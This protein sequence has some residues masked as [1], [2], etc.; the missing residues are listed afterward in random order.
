MYV[1]KKTGKPTGPCETHTCDADQR[2]L[3][4]VQNV[5]SQSAYPQLR[6]IRCQCHEGA[7]TLQ[8]R[9]PSYYLKQVA[10]QLIRPLPHLARIYNQLEVGGGMPHTGHP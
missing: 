4:N 7:I 6:E 3:E 10:Q 9:V 1:T 8:G 2:L 5:L